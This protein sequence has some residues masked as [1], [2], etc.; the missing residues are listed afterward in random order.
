PLPRAHSVSA[1]L[2]LFY[3]FLIPFSLV[4]SVANHFEAACY[5]IEE[6]P[7]TLRNL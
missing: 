5:L 2:L 1:V 4:T 6:T 7:P 3:S